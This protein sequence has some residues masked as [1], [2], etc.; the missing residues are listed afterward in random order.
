MESEKY[1]KKL[2]DWYLRQCNGDWEHEYGIKIDTIDNP[3]WSLQIDLS[4]TT[5]TGKTFE[6]IRRD[7]DENNWVHCWVAE[8][9]FQAGGGPLNL[10]DL[11]KEFVEWAEA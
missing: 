6:K 5:L 2:Q 3:G 11:I 7:V 10:G 8:N 1:Y 9:K 4:G